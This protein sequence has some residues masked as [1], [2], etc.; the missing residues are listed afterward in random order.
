[1]SYMF[2]YYIRVIRLIFINIEYIERYF[3]FWNSYKWVINLG[4]DLFEWFCRGNIGGFCYRGN[5][6]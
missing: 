5:R 4:I 6:S 1:M 2:L 3:N